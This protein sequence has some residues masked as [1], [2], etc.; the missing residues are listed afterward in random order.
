[1]EL[2]INLFSQLF[3]YSESSEYSLLIDWRIKVKELNESIKNEYFTEVTKKLFGADKLLY[4]H[5]NYPLDNDDLINHICKKFE[6]SDRKWNGKKDDKSLESLFILNEKK[7]IFIPIFIHNGLFLYIFLR[8]N[9]GCFSEVIFA[10]VCTIGKQIGTINNNIA[11]K[12]SSTEIIQ[13]MS[14]QIIAPLTG[15]DMHIN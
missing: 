4:N 3:S 12:H 14:H 13:S 9:V 8:K 1:M 2:V 5:L 7:L 15:L 11:L 6:S 10:L